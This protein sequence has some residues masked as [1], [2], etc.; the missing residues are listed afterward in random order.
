[1]PSRLQKSNTPITHPIDYLVARGVDE[2][3]AKQ[4]WLAAKLALSR[5]TCQV[6]PLTRFDVEAEKIHAQEIADAARRFADALD[7]SSD[8]LWRR[9]ADTHATNPGGITSDADVTNAERLYEN[10]DSRLGRQRANFAANVRL[11]SHAAQET[12][13]RLKKPGRPVGEISGLLDELAVIWRRAT[14]RAPTGSSAGDFER[15]RSYFGE[16][17]SLCLSTLPA[18]HR[19]ENGFADMIRRAAKRYCARNPARVA[20]NPA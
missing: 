1:M 15:P 10:W 9:L 12:V 19:F 18:S 2:S 6:A 7:G 16:F 13:Q 17:V 11:V 5:Y 8:I 4:A 20:Q 14:G 3:R